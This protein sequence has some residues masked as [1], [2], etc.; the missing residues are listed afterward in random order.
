MVT[1]NTCGLIFQS[2]HGKIIIKQTLS[3]SASQKRNNQETS[4]ILTVMLL[5][6]MLKL[7]MQAIHTQV[8]VNVAVNVAT[9]TLA[10]TNKCCLRK[11]ASQTEPLPIHH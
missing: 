9:I 6:M 3:M 4:Y 10:K 11:L 2:P 1:K 5:N 8:A 7:W